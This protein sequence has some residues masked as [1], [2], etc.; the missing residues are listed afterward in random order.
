MVGL[1]WFL[2]FHGEN[3]K[4]MKGSREGIVAD[5]MVVEEGHGGD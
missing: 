3:G 1:W 4:Q 2:F 5:L